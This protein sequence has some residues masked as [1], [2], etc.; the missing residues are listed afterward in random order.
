[1]K[2]YALA[3]DLGSK[4]GRGMLGVLE[5][6]SIR[7]MQEVHR[8]ENAFVYVQGET[9]WDYLALYTGIL[10]CIRI[11]HTQGIRIDSIGIDGWAQDYAYIGQDGEV[12][13]LPR[14]YRGFQSK[15]SGLHFEEAHALD[16]GE[17][18][19]ACGVAY[20]A[21]S[22][23]RQL[24]HDVG[25]TPNQ[26]AYSKT[27]L[28]VPYLM[29][30][31]LTGV[32]AYDVSLPVIGELG[33]VAS[34]DFRQKTLESLGLEGKIP[35]RFNSGEIIGYTHESVVEA[36]GHPSIPVICTQA[37]DTTSAV[38][39]IPDENEFY[40]ISNGSFAMVGA[41]LTQQ[42]FDR[43]IL[44]AGFCNTPMADGRNCL[45]GGSGA[46]MYYLQQ[47][48]QAWREKGMQVDYEELTAYALAHQSDR[49]F[50]FDD[51]PSISTDMPTEISDAI[52]KAGFDRI[53]DP[54]ELYEAFSNSLARLCVEKIA[55]LVERSKRSCDAVYVVSGGAKASDINQRVARL[56]GKPVYAGLPEASAMGNLLAQWNTRIDF[57]KNQKWFAMRRFSIEL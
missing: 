49:Y 22:T 16:P 30:Y 25:N 8:F 35:R 6:G 15:E 31:L 12:L 34:G 36:T 37:H 51:L 1:M 39:A 11:C 55:F 44:D 19:D 10:Q 3:I 26:V 52:V 54:L 4:S 28:F 38:S 14:S 27:F 32:S 57:Q 24:W 5:D 2:H 40:W 23:L 18:R 9:Y 20:G 56:L 42:L 48:V 21:I 50:S 53:L 17:F 47:C 46:G 43:T 13:G 45:M 33:D 29:V 7:R 41:V